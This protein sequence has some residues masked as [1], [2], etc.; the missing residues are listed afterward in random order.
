MPDPRQP[1]FWDDEYKYLW[2]RFG[3]LAMRIFGDGAQA[4]AALLP[5]SLELLINWDTFNR[6]AVDWAKN[7]GVKW[8]HGINDVTREN[9]VN[10]IEEWIKNG[11]PLPML[12][13]RL[14]PWFDKSRAARI[15]TTEVTRIYSEGNQAAWKS[16]GFVGGKR[17]NT[18]MDERVCPMCGPLEGKVVALNNYFP[19]QLAGG[20]MGPPAHV[21]CRCWVTPI[22]DIRSVEE[23][24]GE[25]IRGQD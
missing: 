1:S 24:I 9:T 15:A 11:E 23:R 3:P 21:N 13:Q 14:A 16:T 19:V 18:A 7:Y 5:A 25:A 12:K 6:Q 22:V 4:G 20:V 8:L 17:W 2:E 10:A